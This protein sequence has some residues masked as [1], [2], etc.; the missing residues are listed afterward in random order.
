MK[1]IIF[2]SLVAIG[3][4]VG[5]AAIVLAVFSDEQDTTG[6]VVAALATDIDL[7]ICEPGEIAGPDCGADDDG[8]PGGPPGENE[9]I[10]EGSEQ[11]TPGDPAIWDLRMR[12]IGN[13]PWDIDAFAVDIQETNDPNGDC[14]AAVEVEPKI[15]GKEGDSINDNHSTFTGT[16]DPGSMRREGFGGATYFVHVDA[17]DYEDIR[18]RFLLPESAGNECS[19]NAWDITISWTVI[20]EGSH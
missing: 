3:L 11:L 8:T 13:L 18:L 2:A 17:G 14:D 5:A 19:A 4:G 20:D 9:A 7:H 1:R 10:F 15:L 12:N 16:L 6:S